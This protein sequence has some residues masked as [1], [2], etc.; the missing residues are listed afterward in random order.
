[1]LQQL[2]IGRLFAVFALI[3]SML[4][5]HG[6]CEKTSSP[7]GVFFEPLEVPLVSIEVFVHDAD[8]KPV[9]G[10]EQDDFE[11]FEDGEAVEISH[12]YASLEQSAAATTSAEAPGQPSP[13]PSQNL[14]LVVFIDETNFT[15]GLRREALRN[16]KEF[17]STALP[18][19]LKVM[20]VSY[21][22][23]LHIR[24]ALTASSDELLATVTDLE[25]ESSMNNKLAEKMVITSIQRQANPTLGTPASQGSAETFTVRDTENEIATAK[26]LISEIDSLAKE[27]RMRTLHQ[28]KILRGFIRSFAGLP[29]RKAVFYLSDGIALRPG[30]DLYN[31]WQ[32]AFPGLARREGFI[33]TARAKRYSVEDE[34]SD[35]VRYANAYRVSFY[36]VSTIGQN[37]LDANSAENRGFAG[38]SGIELMSF[39]QEEAF[40]RMASGTGGRSLV[41]NQRLDEQLGEVAVELKS[42]YSLGF[43]PQHSGDSKF[44]R[45]KVKVKR[46]GVKVRHREGYQSKTT[47]EKMADRT[48]SAAIHRITENPLGILVE[49]STQQPRD[50]GTFTVPVIIKVPL[51]QLVLQPQ[52]TQ[53]EG[54]ISLFLVVRDFEGGISDV[55]R[56][57]YPVQ[58]P[59][60]QLLDAISQSAGFALGLVMRPGK[61]LVA[62]GVRDELSNVEATALLEVN[63]GSDGA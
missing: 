49:T 6:W 24:Q 62:V 42:Y 32:N 10:L 33:A 61:Q 46:E 22:G 37:M 5:S 29:G 12:F 4:P 54:R 52:Q 38:A 35:V 47:A 27:Q 25:D 40:L 44:H 36:C 51:N 3:M 14:F 41:N 11:V 19:D 26:S 7:K 9:V 43:R 34:L 13:T 53:H 2:S 17:F 39:S 55:Q 21:D 15:Y 58:I 60:N 30:E 48:I 28:I 57:E 56:R 1:M 18:A 31:I 50:D 16:L 8:G 63:V 59:N 45:I 20:L 23:A